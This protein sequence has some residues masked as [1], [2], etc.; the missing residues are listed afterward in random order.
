[1]TSRRSIALGLVIGGV[2]VGLCAGC[3]TSG[4]SNTAASAQTAS[5]D[6]SNTQSSTLGVQAVGGLPVGF[7]FG[8]GFTRF[9][10]AGALLIGDPLQL[11][12][13]QQD[14]ADGV[15]DQLRSTMKQAF[16]DAR[17]QIRG[18]L[19]DDQRAKLD[20]LRANFTPG[21]PPLFFPG[22]D[23]I[24][25]ALGLTD[26]QKTQIQSI[27]DA[28]GEQM[29]TARETA[30]SDFRAILT[31]DQLQKLDDFESQFPKPPDGFGGL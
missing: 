21:V 15:F 25:S 1:M 10:A 23:S 28:L 3:G 2:L 4:T 29:K 6:S 16:R 5:G 24:D 26:D 14:Q 9:H 30:Q 7:G 22:G 19:T 20:D 11:T 17:D 12:D 13:A 18:L 31:P 27:L 8:G